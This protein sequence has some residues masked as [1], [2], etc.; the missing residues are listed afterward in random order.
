[1]RLKHDK[2]KSST[3]L[4]NEFNNKCFQLGLEIHKEYQAQEAQA[5]LKDE[6]IEI[7][8]AYVAAMEREAAIAESN[9]RA[10]D[11]TKAFEAKNPNKPVSE[12]DA[13]VTTPTP[14]PSSPSTE[15]AP[16]EGNV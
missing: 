13:G 6:Q 1:M 9:K 8:E 16:S 11:N 10:E 7:E 12:A 5:K 14:P 15:T 4:R 2:T 3:E